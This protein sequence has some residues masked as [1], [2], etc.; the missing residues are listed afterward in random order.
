MRRVI[1]MV[2]LASILGQQ[3]SATIVPKNVIN[4]NNINSIN[5]NMVWLGSGVEDGV[6]EEI[7]LEV[8]SVE[9][10]LDGLYQDIASKL[11][12]KAWYVKSMHILAGGKAIYTDKAPDIYKDETVRELPG[13]FEID[14]VIQVYDKS[15]DGSDNRD[16]SKYYIPDA[17]YNVMYTIKS[18]MDSRALVDRGYMQPYFD[19]LLPD[20]KQNVLFYEAVLEYLG[21]VDEEINAFYNAYERVIYNKDADEYVVGVGSDG[22]YIKDE[23]KGIFNKYGVSDIDK[24]AE[25]LSFD[26]LLVEEDNPDNIKVSVPLHYKV[27]YT[28]RENMMIAALSLVGKVRYVWGGGHGAT[29]NINGI[30][31]IWLSID[32]IYRESGH[33]DDSIRPNGTWCPVHGD[34]GATS[35]TCM[36]YD[37][38]VTDINE[39][40][41]IRGS[42]IGDIVIPNGLFDGNLNV[43]AHRVEGLDCSGFASWLYNQID[44]SRVYDSSAR[45][46]VSSSGLS[47]VRFGDKLLPGD[48][49]AWSSHICIIIGSIDDTNKVYLEVESTPDVVKVGVAYYPGATQAQIN[50]ARELAKDANKILGDID[51]G[52][53]TFN[54]AN[55]GNITQASVD[56]GGNINYTY[57]KSLKIGRLS[58]EYIDEY[59]IVEGYGKTMSEMTGQEIIQ[60]VISKL[61]MTYLYGI[62]TYSGGNYNI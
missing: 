3:A 54:L 1:S 8:V 41:S 60:D 52:I 10:Q 47:E 38:G 6:K 45:Y 34:V 44:N 62:D 40:L 4:S 49:V 61:P 9:E 36:A 58:R 27:G 28:G 15:I 56:E 17:A 29:G 46:F 53:N 43:E 20:V 32:K 48:A 5:G 23:F 42:L 57:S 30:N 21:V 14:G 51:N 19:A 7:Q 55:I 35:N 13:A 22:Y 26:S 16:V 24:I 37:V 2:I 25:L 11:G 59:D 50:Y 33:E 18:I 31:P 39:Y 12:L